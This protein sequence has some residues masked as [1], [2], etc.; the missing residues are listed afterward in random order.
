MTTRDLDLGVHTMRVS[1][2]AAAFEAVLTVRADYRRAGVLI[3]LRADP[4]HFAVSQYGPWLV[5]AHADEVFKYRVRIHKKASL[6]AVV[7]DASRAWIVRWEKGA[8]C[9]TTPHPPG[10]AAPSA[11]GTT[12]VK[13]SDEDTV[14]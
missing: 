7:I 2:R 9:T 1:H 14:P 10:P 6:P 12:T 13:L 5:V 4:A 8:R 3:D 11:A